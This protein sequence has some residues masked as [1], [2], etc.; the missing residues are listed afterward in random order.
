MIVT[1]VVGEV[2]ERALRCATIR[3]MMRDDGVVVVLRA[4]YCVRDAH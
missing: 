2:H 4:R 3:L 1:R